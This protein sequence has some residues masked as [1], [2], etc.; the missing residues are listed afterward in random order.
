VFSL[1]SGGLFT[2]LA[3]FDSS[4]GFNTYAGVIADSS[5]TLYGTTQN[6]GVHNYGTVFSLTTGGVLTTLFNFTAANGQPTGGLIADASGTF[7]GTTYTG[8]ANG[9]GSVFSLTTGGVFTTVAS[10]DATNGAY[11]FARLIADAAGTLYGTTQLGCLDGCYGS[12]FSVTD[13]GFDAGGTGAVPEPASWA[14]LIAGF[15]L[16]GAAMRRRRVT[17]VAA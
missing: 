6:G 7:F 4:S 10:F 17:A 3:S 11:P 1:T 5:G 2:T 14:M 8:G 13:S 12:V 16:T 15:G 9:F